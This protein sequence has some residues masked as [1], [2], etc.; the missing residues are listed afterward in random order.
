[1]CF[2]YKSLFLPPPP[3]KKKKIQQN[4]TK[5]KPEHHPYTDLCEVLVFFWFQDSIYFFQQ[6]K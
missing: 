3:P 6:T 4:K 5:Q 2:T 1:M